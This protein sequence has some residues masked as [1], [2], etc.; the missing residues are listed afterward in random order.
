MAAASNS[1]DVVIVGAGP[2]G[3]FAAHQIAKA[4]WRV[5]LLEEHREIGEPVQCGGLVTP[6]VFDYVSCKETILG[7]VRGAEIFSPKGRAIRIDGGEAKAVV[8]DRAMFD[9]AIVTESIR[10]G[11]ETFLGTQA[12]GATRVD[13]RVEVLAIRDGVPFRLRTR[14][15]LGCDGVRSNVAK[16][17]GILKPKK[18]LPGFE[19]EMTGVHSDPDFVQ[20]FVGNRFA[21]GFFGWIIPSGDTARVGLCVGH[22]NAHAFLRTMLAEPHVRPFVEGA[23]PIV[24]IAGGIP[25]GFPRRSHADNVMVVGDAACHAKAT[26]GGGIFTGL[27]CADLA[28][29]TA[30]QA[31]EADD[32]SAKFLH[33]YHKAW[34]K[35]IG[36][37][38]RKDL[39]IHESFA[40]LTDEQLEELFDLL[41]QPEILSLIERKGDID[42]PSKVGWALLRKEPRLLKYTGK[43]LRAMIAKTVGI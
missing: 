40:R 37:E 13:G 3:G 26:S 41:G 6:R 30:V 17:F 11:A 20:L 39:A 19:I 34:T 7:Q 10:A 24:Y 8:V 9:R 42:F 4:G 43:V 25:L 2:V 16:W 1:F 38:L 22:G 14:L 35:S 31:L 5:A 33:R 18:I 36:K 29:K 21:P 15:L 32:V 23:Q 27:H 12:Q 28:A